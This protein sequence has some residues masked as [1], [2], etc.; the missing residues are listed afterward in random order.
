MNP[1]DKGSPL[2]FIS[3]WAQRGFLCSPS[4]QTIVEPSVTSL[5]IKVSAASQS[6]GTFACLTRMIV[7][8]R[9]IARSAQG[10]HA[11]SLRV[12]AWLPS[13]KVFPVS[14]CFYMSRQFGL[15]R[16][17]NN[18]GWCEEKGSFPLEPFDPIIESAQKEQ[19]PFQ[20]LPF[21]APTSLNGTGQQDKNLT[22]C[23]LVMIAQR[24]CSFIII[25]LREESI[26]FCLPFVKS[27]L[28][29]WIAK[30][31]NSPEMVAWWMGVR[32]THSAFIDK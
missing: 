30:E 24:G 14:S 19:L 27:N 13:C 9:S 10:L 11:V 1:R 17:E 6:Q 5:K 16:R 25:L 28:F 15:T 12:S 7:E 2:E 3:F 4:D 8:L 31:I 20:V 29:L 26:C 18:A 21:G 22:A 23:S 32:A